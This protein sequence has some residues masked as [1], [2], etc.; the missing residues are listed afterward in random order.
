MMS[1]QG[2]V[3]LFLLPVV[4][5]F[6]FRTWRC[7]ACNASRHAESVSTLARYRRCGVQLRQ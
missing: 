1:N 5:W 2:A 6:A 3:C 4:A 7:P